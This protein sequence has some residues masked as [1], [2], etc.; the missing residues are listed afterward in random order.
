MEKVDSLIKEGNTLLNSWSWFNPYKDERA[1]ELFEK[2]AKICHHNNQNDKAIDLYDKALKCK[3]PDFE[4]AQIYE[5]K[6]N[7]YSLNSLKIQDMEESYLKAIYYY[8]S[9]TY[10]NNNLRIYKK[11]SDYFYN[12]EIWEKAE[13]YLDLTSQNE[14]SSIT[15]KSY[16][17]KLFYTQIHMGKY[18]EAIETSKFISIN[19]ESSAL[20]WSLTQ[21]L[22]KAGL[23]ALIEDKI[24]CKRN[25]EQYKLIDTNY[26]K[27]PYEL[28]EKLITVND[29]NDFTDI[30]SEYNRTSKFDE[31]EQLLLL[32]I[33]E[34]FTDNDSLL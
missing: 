10:F 4:K 1:A 7:I 30:I 34:T 15:R 22:F 19:L 27:R 2:A 16:L 25:V 12:K 24:I 29:V 26:N 33:K 5:E 17:E 11:I 6:A 28:L 23:C 20:R 32:K 3:I 13:K 31:I 14:T 8:E 18:N 9:C 21:I